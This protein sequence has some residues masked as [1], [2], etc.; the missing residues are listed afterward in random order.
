MTMPRLAA[1]FETT[2]AAYRLPIWRTERSA[3]MA[4]LSCYYNPGED[5]TKWLPE[6]INTL[7]DHLIQ[8]PVPM[9]CL[10]PNWL[11]VWQ[12][13]GSK[14][15][16]PPDYDPEIP[17]RQ[18]QFVAEKLWLVLIG[19]S[20]L[21][22]LFLD[23]EVSDPRGFAARSKFLRTVTKPI[24]DLTGCERVNYTDATFKGS[25]VEWSGFRRLTGSTIDHTD[26][27][28]CYTKKPGD[29]VR[30]IR[31][32]LACRKT[33]KVI[34]HLPPKITDHQTQAEAE[35]QIRAMVHVCARAGITT[36]FVASYEWPE[37]KWP[38]LVEV[39]TN[40][41]AEAEAIT[42]QEATA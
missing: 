29:F 22:Y 38:R 30:V 18:M 26:S 23:H 33:G 27:V 3:S 34:P 17:L 25:I 20:S 31:N 36:F 9:R 15:E 5:P 2:R 28:D 41:C 11:G 10:Y 39:V 6:Q 12:Y 4:H 7:T 40:A 14:G 32:V 16:V 42:T 19:A 8:T 1:I 13:G 35:S 21:P 24:K 37:D